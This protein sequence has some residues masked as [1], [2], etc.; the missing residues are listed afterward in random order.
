MVVER[1]A[2]QRTNQ[3]VLSWDHRMLFVQLIRVDDVC[4]PES[5]P[6]M[7]TAFVILSTAFTLA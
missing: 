6:V 4:C 2:R 5:S 3:H 7:Q 1:Q